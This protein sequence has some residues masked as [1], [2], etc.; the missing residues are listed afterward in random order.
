M[1]YAKKVYNNFNTQQTT[2]SAIMACL[3]KK[4]KKKKV[5]KL[6]IDCWRVELRMKHVCCVMLLMQQ[7]NSPQWAWAREPGLKQQQ[8]H[9]CG[10]TGAHRPPVCLMGRWGVTSLGGP[11]RNPHLALVISGATQLKWDILITRMPLLFLEIIILILTP[12]ITCFPPVPRLFSR[13]PN[14][15]SNKQKSN[16]RNF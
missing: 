7:I 12:L 9:V 3:G 14:R 4:E 16:P 5:R 10:L 1:P 2:R 11:T 15:K 13:E 6:E 8:S